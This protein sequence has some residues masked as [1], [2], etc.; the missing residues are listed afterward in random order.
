MVVTFFTCQV[1]LKSVSGCL[2]ELAYE[3]FGFL[4]IIDYLLENGLSLD[5]SFYGRCLWGIIWLS[6]LC[7]GMNMKRDDFGQIFWSCLSPVVNSNYLLKLFRSIILQQGRRFSFWRIFNSLKH[8]LT[9]KWSELHYKM[10]DILV[11]DKG[12]RCY[13]SYWNRKIQWL[14]K[15]SINK[16]QFLQFCEFF[17]FILLYLDLF[18]IWT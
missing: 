16:N 9:G 4:K 2:N 17:M 6:C 15:R 11:F 1:C 8:I 10:L 3:S 14:L 7:S 12:I 18:N 13:H 5:F